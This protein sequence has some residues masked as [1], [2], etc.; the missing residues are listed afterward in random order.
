[1]RTVTD[2][3]RWIRTIKMV[4]PKCLDLFYAG[5]LRVVFGES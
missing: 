3:N 4:Y 2:P 1:M 5:D